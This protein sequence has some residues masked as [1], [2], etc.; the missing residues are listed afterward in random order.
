MLPNF[1]AKL[2]CLKSQPWGLEAA[3]FLPEPWDSI[4]EPVTWTVTDHTLGG[5]LWGTWTKGGVV[6]TLPRRRAAGSR[7]T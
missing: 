1:G 5:N 7:A 3:A 2:R 4:P 6:S